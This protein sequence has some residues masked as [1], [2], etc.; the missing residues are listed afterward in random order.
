M[1]GQIEIFSI[2]QVTVVILS[3][4]RELQ[5]RRSVEYWNN[6]HLRV[7]ILHNTDSPLPSCLFKHNVTYVVSVTDFASRSKIAAGM[8][9]T[10]YAVLCSDDEL[11]LPTGL[12]RMGQFLEDHQEVLSIGGRT[13]ALGKSGSETTA[14]YIYQNMS[15]YSNFEKSMLQRLMHHTTEQKDY[16][17]GSM[18]R[19]MHSDLMTEM[20]KTFSELSNVSTP[21]IYEVTG[22]IIVNGKGQ[23]VYL[24]ELYWI[25]N[26]INDQI[27]H[28]NWDRKLYFHQWWE[29]VQFRNEHKIWINAL[30]STLGATLTSEEL[31]EVLDDIFKK[32]KLLEDHEIARSRGIKNLLPKWVRSAKHRIFQQA[33]GENTLAT[34]MQGINSAEP[35]IKLELQNAASHMF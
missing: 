7:L 33:R 14:T 8:I 27:E 10:K 17:S 26:W 35:Q 4:G 21:Y 31:S 15:N 1:K 30:Q 22:E 20:L 34:F 9:Q 25:R 18:Y 23:G 29:S 2:D 12:S 16:K 24:K 13:L 6:T 3:R 32:R 5:L 19:L 11:L 28:T